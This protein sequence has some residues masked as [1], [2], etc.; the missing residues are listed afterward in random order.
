MEG[1]FAM[2][3]LSRLHSWMWRVRCDVGSMLGWT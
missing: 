2:M 3:S 1:E